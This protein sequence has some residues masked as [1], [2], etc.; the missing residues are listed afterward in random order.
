[1]EEEKK[2]GK[3]LGKGREKD[4][5]KKN[6]FLPHNSVSLLCFLSVTSFC[7]SLIWDKSDRRQTDPDR[8][9]KTSAPSPPTFPGLDAAIN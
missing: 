1:M 6:H 9:A 4:K 7:C 5:K 3:K 2:K 8:T